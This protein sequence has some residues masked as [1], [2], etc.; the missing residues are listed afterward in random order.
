MIVASLASTSREEMILKR[1]G[2]ALAVCLLG[3]W[4]AAPADA[5][6][7]KWTLHDVTFVDGATASGSFVF[8]ADTGAVSSVNIV[9]TD[10]AVVTGAT[11][12]LADPGFTA[13]GNFA[14]FVTGIFAD[15]TGTPA[16]AIGVNSPMTDGGGTLPLA[17]AGINEGG[18]YTCGNAAC[19]FGDSTRVFTS[20][21]ISATGVPEPAT[22]TL[23][24]GG[25]LGFGLRRIRRSRA[26]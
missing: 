15:F 24:G 4:T 17:L 19:T 25:L 10:G 14:V 8:D 16:L 20:G 21:S 23:L 7:I 6:P 18:E 9:T 13:V 1:I 12:T 3:A 26:K 5:T 2:I 22:L 11:Y